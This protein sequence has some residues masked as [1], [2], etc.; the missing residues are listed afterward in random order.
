[1]NNP[2][3]I[4]EHVDTILKHIDVEKIRL[5]KFKV[6]V[7]MT[8]GAACVLDPYFFEQLGIELVSINNIPN[9]K[10]THKPEPLKENLG[11]IAALVKI[12]NADIGFAQDPDADR[13]VVINEY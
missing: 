3:F 8:N 10:F 6:A 12:S 9:G 7:D 11:E 4:K 13:L 1:M 5:R 2:D